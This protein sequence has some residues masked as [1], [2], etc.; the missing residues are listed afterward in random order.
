MNTYEVEV[1][2][3]SRTQPDRPGRMVVR[4]GARRQSTAEEIAADLACAELEE[5][6]DVS[7]RITQ[8]R[9][10]QLLLFTGAL[11]AWEA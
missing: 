7:V 6:D 2:F 5:A 4:I 1:T 8:V 3:V 10:R 11:D 9:S